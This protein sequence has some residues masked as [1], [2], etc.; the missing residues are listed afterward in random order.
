M[1]AT[2]PEP[3][4]RGSAH[5]GP[6][7]MLAG[8]GLAV[9]IAIGTGLLLRAAK[10][11]RSFPVSTISSISRTVEPVSIPICLSATPWYRSFWTMC[12]SGPS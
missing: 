4:L 6:S 10:G 2:L 8:P 11:Y 5:G 7:G 1:S 12:P 3:D 9:A